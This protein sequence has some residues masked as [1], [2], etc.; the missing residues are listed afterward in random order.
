MNTGELKFLNGLAWGLFIMGLFNSVPLLNKLIVGIVVLACSIMSI[1]AL[2]R[3]RN[4]NN[5]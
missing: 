4:D 2:G 3:G 5:N 1:N